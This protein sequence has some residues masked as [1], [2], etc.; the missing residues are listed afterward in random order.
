MNALEQLGAFERRDDRI[1]MRFERRYPRAIE[2]VWSALTDPARLQD[3][4]GAAFVEPRAGGRYELMLDGPNPMIGHIVTWEPPH[5]LEFTWRNAHAPDSVA[6]YE[7]SRDGDGACVIFTH[8]GAPF[9]NR[10][11]MLPGWHFFFERL[12]GLL[13]EGA[14]RQS[15]HGWRELQAI[16]VER[17]K[18]N[19]ARLDP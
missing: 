13:A 12:G 2:K 4:M 15:R 19:D 11:L 7:L 17:H 6:R 8:K 3:W 1:D 18:L 16:Y 5:V 9:A 10:A 14:V